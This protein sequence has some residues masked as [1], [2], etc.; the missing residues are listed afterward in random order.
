[1]KFPK[2]VLSQGKYPPPPSSVGGVK[3]GYK[4][5]DSAYST[6]ANKYDYKPSAHRPQPQPRAPSVGARPQ[7]MYMQQPGAQQ[8]GQQQAGATTRYSQTNRYSAGA[9]NRSSTYGGYRPVSGTQTSAYGTSQ[10]NRVSTYQ[11]AN[12]RST[13]GQ[14][15]SSTSAYGMSQPPRAPY[16]AR[17]QASTM[18]QPNP[19]TSTTYASRYSGSSQAGGQGAARPGPRTYEQQVRD[20]Q[21]A[22][23]KLQA[24]AQHLSSPG[25]QAR[26]PSPNRRTYY[27]KK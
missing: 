4:P 26:S 7:S 16:G 21:V 8:Y 24:S 22:K 17:P 3:T 14:R 9:N 18:P 2:Q 15:Q 19:R 12:R 25:G 20:R 13:Y 10:V 23:A 1:M 6:K 27:Q 11:Q 5:N